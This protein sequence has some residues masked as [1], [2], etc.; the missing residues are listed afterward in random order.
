[1][2]YIVQLHNENTTFDPNGKTTLYWNTADET[3]TPIASLLSEE[4]ALSIMATYK[5]RGYKPEM[6]LAEVGVL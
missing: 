3:F 5:D 2:T 1:M 6:V 4:E